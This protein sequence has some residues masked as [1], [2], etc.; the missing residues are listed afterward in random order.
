VE[1]EFGKEE[2]IRN[3]FFDENL[4]IDSDPILIP[5]IVQDTTPVIEKQCSNYC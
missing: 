3:F 4:V 1:V 5:I 2:N